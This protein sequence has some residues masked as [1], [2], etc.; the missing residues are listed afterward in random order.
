[1]AFFTILPKRQPPVRVL[2]GPGGSRVERTQVFGGVAAPPRPARRASGPSVREAR[3]R[4]STALQLIEE[5][6]RLRRE[7]ERLRAELEAC[8]RPEASSAAESDPDGATVRFSLLEI[9]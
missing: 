8:R 3:D 6:E 7:N 2:L 4:P 5:N 9:D 1:M